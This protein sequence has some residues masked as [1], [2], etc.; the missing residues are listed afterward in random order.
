MATVA[1][2]RERSSSLSRRSQPG[3]SSD[4][5]VTHKAQP[6]TATSPS[7]KKTRQRFLLRRDCRRSAH[8]RA[9][10]AVC[11][12]T[13]TVVG[14]LEVDAF[15]Y[16]LHA[17][18]QF[19]ADRKPVPVIEGAVGDGD[20]LARSVRPG[21]SI[22]PDLMA[23]LPSPTSPWIVRYVTRGHDLAGLY[24]G[25]YS[26]LTPQFNGV[27]GES[28]WGKYRPFYR[29]PFCVYVGLFAYHY[30]EPKRCKSPSSVGS[31]LP[32][33]AYRVPP[34]ARCPDSALFWTIRTLSRR[35]HRGNLSST[36]CLCRPPDL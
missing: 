19:T 6:P 36:D 8:A 30:G 33:G 31:R 12:D 25:Q 5:P 14:A 21:E 18:S 3:R 24:S 22:A 9:A 20:V 15:V 34:S 13:Y 35:S 11:L 27:R 23:M 28:A 4:L 29:R 17:A 26:A 1:F 16:V 32:G 7:R 10:V 2:F